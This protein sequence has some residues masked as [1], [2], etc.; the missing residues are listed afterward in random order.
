MISNKIL[1]LKKDSKLKNGL[2]FKKGT[3][4]HIVMDVVYMQGFPLPQGLQATIMSW[5]DN[6]KALFNEIQR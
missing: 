1:V 5:L 6:N 4:L 2:E 3:E